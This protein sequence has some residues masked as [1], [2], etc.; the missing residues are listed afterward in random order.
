VLVPIRSCVVLGLFSC[1][2]SA[3]AADT[4]PPVKQKKDAQLWSLAPVVR[5]GIPPGNTKAANPIDAFVTAKLKEKSLRS[6]GPA[7]KVTLLRRLYIN[8]IGIPPSPAEQDAFLKDSSPDA[9][10]NV[11]DHLLANEQ[12]GV[13]Y[14]RHWLD[15]LRYADADERMLAAPGIHMWRDWVISALNKDLPYDQFVRVQLTGYRTD[16]RTQM[17]ATGYRSKV[18][19]RPEDM[20]ALGFLARGDVIRDNH[21]VGELPITAV[22]T[23]STAFMGMTVGC[24]K[25]HDHMYD[26]IKQRAFYSMKAL[27]DPLV[28]KKVTLASPAE[29]ASHG[30]A[31]DE[32]EVKRS[33][34]QASIDA[35]AGPYEKKLYDERVA[36]TPPDVRVIIR[37]A[38]K[39]RT[40]AEQK[41]ADD[42]FPVLRIDSGPLKESMPPEVAEKY[43]GLTRKLNQEAR[44]PADL[45]ATWIV[46]VDGKREAEK[47]YILT[48]GDVE[49]PEKDREVQ[50]GWP[51]A[52]AN[53]DLRNGRVDAFAEWLT[54]ANNPFFARVAVNRLWQWSFGEG[55][56]KTASDFGK[57]G[58]AP[59]NRELLDWLAS[60]FVAKGY[61]MKA[62]T[63]LIVTS[64][65]YKRS[66][67]AS[68]EM[69][70]S[71][72]KVDPGN[73]YFWRFNLQ[74]LE[75]EPLWDSILSAAGDLDLS[76]GGKSFDPSPQAGPRGGGRNNASVADTRMNRR[77]A[78]MVR[79]YSPNRDIVP[80][81]LTAFDVDDGRVPCPLRTQTVTAPQSLFMMNSDAI[82][83]ASVK[84][85]DRS[86]KASSGD[87]AQAVDLEYQL[88]L[89]RTPSS[90]E[91]DSAL[92]F[93]NSDPAKLKSLAWILLNLDEFIYVR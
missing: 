71:N 16:A 72:N 41:I 53:V 2:I 93:V 73:S 91:K 57:L 46:E 1:C 18:E 23:V 38:E 3:V 40:P 26:P 31:M 62:L 74:R 52:P 29:I 75:A 55:L 56:Q 34:I 87:L 44:R 60:E 11:V 32:Y 7:D 65:A 78:Y 70:T 50:P 17:S 61:S 42:Y 24:A 90:A 86:S 92:T 80:N 20:F 89:S 12:Y 21:E 37:K 51:F 10:E 79:G 35:L 77:G 15:V 6:T 76:V 54:A 58:G 47:S 28:V 68:A 30:K 45:P 49:R 43:T 36:M 39:D 84:L 25:C 19:P 88:T 83:A 33:A 67:E 63:R 9:Y 82:D 4:P 59:S 8:L 85:A 14:G 69:I 81:F 64:D 27:F 48:S 13:R 5:P 22:E 66:S